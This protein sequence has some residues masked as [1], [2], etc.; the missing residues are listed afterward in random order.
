MSVLI[1]E[2]TA[3]NNVALE[4]AYS[5][6]CQYVSEARSV[7]IAD[8]RDV[9]PSER[10]AVKLAIYAAAHTEIEAEPCTSALRELT[11]RQLADL[12]LSLGVAAMGDLTGDVAKS[13]EVL[14]GHAPFG[15]SRW[16]SAAGTAEEL[17]ECIVQWLIAIVDR[18][19]AFQSGGATMA[20]ETEETISSNLPSTEVDAGRAGEKFWSIP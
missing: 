17:H 16:V 19:S 1:T 10:D 11:V 9:V 8:V 13:V 6:A 12:A 18:R 4:N 14:L 15:A 7:Q 20:Q 3:R 5:A 2:F